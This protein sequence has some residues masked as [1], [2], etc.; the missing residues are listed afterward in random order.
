MK[1]NITIIAIV[2]LVILGLG[3]L[4]AN[5]RGKMQRAEH[6]LDVARDSIH[7]V[8]L[9]NGELLQ[10]RDSYILKEKE[11]TEYLDI[12][13]QEAKDLKKKLGSSLEEIA[14]LK[15]HVRIDTVKTVVT[16]DSIVFRPD[17]S[18]YVKFMYGDKWLSFRGD[19][20]A[21]PDTAGVTLY[22]V[23]VPIDITTGWDKEGKFFI[24]SP[25]PYVRFGDINAAQLNTKKS[26]Q[27][28]WKLGFQGGM[29]VIYNVPKHKFDA[30]PGVGFGISYNF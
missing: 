6:N 29:Y 30:G 11:L 5:Y 23:D 4:V 19:L 8:T 20:E 24:T 1:S 26:T 12:T 18:V 21:T 7:N 3:L 13:K 27:S 22:D 25:N 14:K 16:K 28:R 10:I 2:A 17:T 9:K 15:G